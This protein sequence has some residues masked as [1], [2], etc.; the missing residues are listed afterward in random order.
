M[1]EVAGHRVIVLLDR[2]GSMDERDCDNQTR[3]NFCQEKLRAF[4]PAAVTSAYGSKVILILFNSGTHTVDVKTADE[5]TKAMILYRTGGSTATHLALEAA[6]KL[7]T[8]DVPTMVFL[9]TDGHPDDEKAVDKEIISITQ[10]M[11]RPEDFRIML[12][13]VGQ[14]DQHLEEWLEHL[15]ND[16]G[17]SGARF[18]IVGQNALEQVDFQEAAAEL[19][20]STTTNSEAAAGQTQGKTTQRID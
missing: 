17:P 19:I 11:T 5:V 14:K 18:D 6:W 7:A 20:G 15:D 16:L 1:L 3:Y 13:T 8:P 9:V 4:V 12:L 10:R 2:S